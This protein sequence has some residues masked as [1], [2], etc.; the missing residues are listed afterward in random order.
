MTV[1]LEDY[2]IGETFRLCSHPL[3]S[4][5]WC[6]TVCDNKVVGVVEDNKFID[7]AQVFRAAP[8]G[9]RIHS[10]PSNNTLY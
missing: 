3:S 1:K 8:K 9:S 2:F 4:V 7:R 10:E 6:I 5:T